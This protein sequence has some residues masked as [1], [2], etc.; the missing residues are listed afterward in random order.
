VKTYEMQGGGY[1][2]AV[3]V[4]YWQKFNNNSNEFGPCRENVTSE[5]Y[6]TKCLNY[7]VLD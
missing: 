7:R 5:N 2:M 3:M 6:S 1:K 4:D